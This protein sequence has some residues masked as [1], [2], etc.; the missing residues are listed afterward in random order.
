MDVSLGSCL[1]LRPGDLLPMPFFAPLLPPNRPPK[2]PFFFF[3]PLSDV[4]VSSPELSPDECCAENDDAGLAG[5]DDSTAASDVGVFGIAVLI[6]VGSWKKIKEKK[7][8]SYR[9]K[10]IAYELSSLTY[11]SFF[12]VRIVRWRRYTTH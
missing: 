5:L 9:D 11:H 2:M 7:Q 10:Q 8:V 6:I 1:D 3:L 4:G 12:T